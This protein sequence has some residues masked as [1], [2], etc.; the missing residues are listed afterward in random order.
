MSN[1]GFRVRGVEDTR[2]ERAISHIETMGV[3]NKTRKLAWSTRRYVLGSFE[4]ECQLY[5]GQDKY[6]RTKV[7]TCRQMG[8]E[9]KNLRMNYIRSLDDGVETALWSWRLVDPV[10]IKDELSRAYKSMDHDVS[11]ANGA[12]NGS[13]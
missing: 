4:V 2:R 8:F 5:R 12:K 1:K 11:V 3:I 6:P 13:K 9:N 7:M 10:V